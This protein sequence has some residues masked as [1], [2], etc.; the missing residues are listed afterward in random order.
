MSKRGDYAPPFEY[1]AQQD[2]PSLNPLVSGGYGAVVGSD[3]GAVPHVSAPVPIP[4]AIG[5]GPPIEWD[6]HAPQGFYA[7]GSRDLSTGFGLENA[8]TFAGIISATRLAKLRAPSVALPALPSSQYLRYSSDASSTPSGIHPTMPLFRA[9]LE[10]VIELAP[11]RPTPLCSPAGPSSVSAKGERDLL[12]DDLSTHPSSVALQ[13]LSVDLLTGHPK[14]SGS[15]R[16]GYIPIAPQV[17]LTQPMPPA[18]PSPFS[19]H[20]LVWSPSPAPSSSHV[21]AYTY[22][23]TRA[24]SALSTCAPS[25]ASIRPL[26]IT[27]QQAILRTMNGG[28]SNS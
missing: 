13:C 16:D 21:S 14:A 26:S 8:S 20:Q 19:V 28:K 15:M 3:L 17:T 22:S 4:G 2:L 6:R 11:I 23:S 27:P 10:L 9:P 24:P 18:C 1:F 12:L 5:T 7:A 25:V